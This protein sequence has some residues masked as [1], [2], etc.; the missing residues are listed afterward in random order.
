M[1]NLRALGGGNP[2]HL[3]VSDAERAERKQTRWG[4]C[5]FDGLARRFISDK[6]WMDGSITI[7]IVA[8]IC[9]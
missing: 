7:C 8:N 6:H 2:L 3:G 5:P 1:S 9:P 4:L